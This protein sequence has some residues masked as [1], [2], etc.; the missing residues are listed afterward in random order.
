[1]LLTTVVTP[2]PK[3]DFFLVNIMAEQNAVSLKLP[4]FWTS[5]PQVWFAQAEAQFAIRKITADET[6]YCYVLSALDQSTATRLLDLINQ[7]PREN[8]YKAMRDRLVDTFC[9]STRERASRLLHTRPLGD[10]KPSALMDEMLAL[11]GDHPP[12]FLF[13]QL[14]LERVPEEIRAHSR[15]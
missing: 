5:H 8:K 15:G 1:M 6:K 2:T 3:N 14:F 10:S 9:L 11:L 7:P 13:E 4:T 12:G